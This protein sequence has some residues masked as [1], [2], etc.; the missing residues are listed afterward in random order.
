MVKEHIKVGRNAYETSKKK[1]KQNV[2]PK[3]LEASMAV[4]PD[5]SGFLA[6]GHLPRVSRQCR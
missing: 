3:K 4:P 5:L 2:R 1:E 6:R